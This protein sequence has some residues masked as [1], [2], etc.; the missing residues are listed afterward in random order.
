VAHEINNPANFAHVGAQSLGA[1]IE[2]FRE[3]LLTLV[4]DGEFEVKQALNERVDNLARQTTTIVD[5]TTR[6]RDLVTD[7]RSFSRLGEADRKAV[8]LSEGLVS[9]IRL[10]QPRF[11]DVACIEC[12]LDADPLVDCWP[13]LLNQVFMNVLVNACQAIQACREQDGSTERGTVRVSDR[14]IGGWVELDVEDDGCGMPPEVQARLFEPFY[15][16]KGVGEGTGLGMSISFGIMQR[17]GGGISV[18]SQA[19]KGSC[20]TLRLRLEAAPEA[21]PA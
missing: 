3:F 2:R 12:R 4:G 14:V 13:A 11:A 16:T 15:T 6:I 1:D 19:G 21:A 9:T 20:V 5:G 8:R 17:H 7:L 18:R 10:V